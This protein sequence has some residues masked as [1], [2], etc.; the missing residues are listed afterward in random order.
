MGERCVCVLPPLESDV[1]VGEL[2]ESHEPWAL[3]LVLVTGK[4]GHDLPV[5][6]RGSVGEALVQ[7]HLRQ[8]EPEQRR[9]VA[10]RMMQDGE[11]DQCLRV[12]PRLTEDRYLGS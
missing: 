5:A 10:C 6:E 3:V 2:E 12:R 11:R 1:E 9:P 8:L 7:V 4:G